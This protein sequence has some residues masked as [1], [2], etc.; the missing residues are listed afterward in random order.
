M[1]FEKVRALWQEGSYCQKILE[2][3]GVCIFSFPGVHTLEMISADQLFEENNNIFQPFVYTAFFGSFSPCQNLN[4][5][6]K[7]YE[8]QPV[9]H[10]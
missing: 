2:F 4:L 5:F 3:G 10:F 6:I 1:K 8:A 9:R 7:L